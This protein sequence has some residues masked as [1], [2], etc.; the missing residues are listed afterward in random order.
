MVKYHKYI[1]RY[2]LD[3][4]NLSYPYD[5]IDFHFAKYNVLLTIADNKCNNSNN[6]ATNSCKRDQNQQ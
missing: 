2:Y 1:K 3:N 6:Y 5:N 4:H